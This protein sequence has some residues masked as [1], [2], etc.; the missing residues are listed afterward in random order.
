[1]AGF[2][3]LLILVKYLAILYTREIQQNAKQYGRSNRL[4]ETAGNN[5]RRSPVRVRSL[6]VVPGVLFPS[7]YPLEFNTISQLY[8]Q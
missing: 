6:A 2:H 4:R 5:R 8:C 7:T 1:M 3:K